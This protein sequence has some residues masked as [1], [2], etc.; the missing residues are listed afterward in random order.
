MLLIGS[1][2]DAAAEEQRVNSPVKALLRLAKAN[3]VDFWADRDRTRRIVQF[4]DRAAQ[5]QEFFD[6]CTSTLAMVYNAMFPRNPQ[7]ENLL[8][9]MGKFKDVRSIHDFMKA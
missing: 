2:L 5:I 3:D 8:E 6:F 7:P 1:F 4:Q 9:I